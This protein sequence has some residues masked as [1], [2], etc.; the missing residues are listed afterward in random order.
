MKII[1]VL[2]C[3]SFIVGCQSRNKLISADSLRT[4]ADLAAQGEKYDLSKF[5]K[6]EI[7]RDTMNG[8]EGWMFYYYGKLKVPGNHFMVWIESGSEKAV[9]FHG[10]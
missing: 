5:E 6:P 9:V 3:L 7:K 8:K 4:K 2:L 1:S 10:E